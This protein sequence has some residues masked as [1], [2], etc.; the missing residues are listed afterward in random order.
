MDY[1]NI[2]TDTLQNDLY[3]KVVHTVPGKFQ[4]VLMSLNPGESIPR[5][6]HA[7]TV[8]FVR[9]EGGRGQ[10]I[11]DRKIYE[12]YDGISLT[13]K[14][15][16]EHEFRNTCKYAKLKLYVIYTPPEHTRGHVDKRQ[17]QSKN[18]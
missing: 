15:N 9:V 2:E 16:V 12:L 10:C 13:I 17:P 3:R 18:K 11:I 6:K 7:N 4:L 14:P 8:Q 1:R 5:E